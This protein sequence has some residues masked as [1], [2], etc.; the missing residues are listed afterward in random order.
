MDDIGFASYADENTTYTLGN[1]VDD[2]IFKLQN[3]S[4]ILFQWLMDNQM[5]ASP[6]KYHLICS[7]ND[8]VNL[9]VENQIIDNSA[10]GK[11]LG[12]KFHYKLTFNA[13]IDITCKKSGLKLNAISRITPYMDFN[14]N[15]Y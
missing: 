6:H 10:C 2:V 4:K 13:H 15:G 1:D 8:T 12:V 5:Q 14:K 7:T 11:P 3:S 9:I